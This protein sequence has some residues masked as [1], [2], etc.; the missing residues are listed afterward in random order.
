[1]GVAS[2]LW[3]ANATKNPA[4]SE[5]PKNGDAQGGSGSLSIAKKYFGLTVHFSI[6]RNK[7][8]SLFY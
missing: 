5:K 8:E 2:R 3:A 7:P 6:I 4:K 1:L